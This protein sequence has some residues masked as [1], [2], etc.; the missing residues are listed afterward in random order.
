MQCRRLCFAPSFLHQTSQDTAKKPQGAWADQSRSAVHTGQR[1][2]RNNPLADINTT[3][4]LCRQFTFAQGH[5][6]VGPDG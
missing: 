4:V 1:T 3:L 2:L 5:S 6:E